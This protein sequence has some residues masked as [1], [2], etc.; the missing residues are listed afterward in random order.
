MARAS[1]SLARLH[2]PSASARL[3]TLARKNN[4]IKINRLLKP[5]PKPLAGSSSFSNGRSRK[6]FKV[7]E[8]RLLTWALLR[9]TVKSWEVEIPTTTFY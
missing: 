7:V 3:L 8:T 2:P 5:K 1:S 6:S 4:I 9:L